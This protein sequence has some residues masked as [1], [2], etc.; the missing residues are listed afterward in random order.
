MIEN[1]KVQ[2]GLI[3]LTLVV[4]LFSAAVIV[5]NTNYYTGSY[6]LAHYLDVNLV[7]IRVANA[8]NE[9]LDPSIRFVLNF[10]TRNDT[11][12]DASLSAI[13]IVSLLNRESIYG[14]AFRMDIPYV[15]GILDA[16][17]NRS[18]TVGSTITNDHD[19]QL[20]YDAYASGNWT[21]S[22]SVY[23]FYNVFNSDSDDRREIG[24]AY[25][26]VTLT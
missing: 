13:R 4:S 3:I 16:N 15:N 7:D 5:G 14:S 11:F 22:V 8:D 24:Y 12:G 6:G 20:L 26:G 1:T 9:S 2:N 10:Q 18:F 17:Y 25:D 23:Y 21:W 19:K